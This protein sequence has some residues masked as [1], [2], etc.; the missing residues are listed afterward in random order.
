MH[1]DEIKALVADDMARLEH[2]IMD[3]SLS[4]MKIANE[5]VTHIIQSG[6]KRVR[7]LTMMLCAHACGYQGDTHIHVAAVLEYIHTATL[8]HDD[9]ID[10]SRLR[11]GEATANAKFGNAPSVL[12]GDFLYSRAFELLVRCED[13]RILAS[14]AQ[15]TNIIAQ[16]ELLQLTNRHNTDI[17]LETYL[18]IIQGKTGELFGISGHV[19]GLLA[20][21]PENQCQQMRDYGMHLGMAFQLIDDALDYK[22]DPLQLG[23]NMG[24]DLAK[25]CLTL[26]LI[27]ALQHGDAEQVAFIRQC[28]REGDING[29]KRIQ[30]IIESLEA[31]TYTIEQAKQQGQLA[32]EAIAFLPSSPYKLALEGLVEFAIA[33]QH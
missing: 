20:Q 26:P 17:K 12:V 33:R 3:N 31:I 6:G 15:A 27:Y 23:K 22:A 11:R 29:L 18:E 7:P 1:I 8:L 30:E 19:A 13:M 28:I 25:G 14:L 9:V 21:L 2:C 16:A 5:I 4:S 10:E 24:D 32:L